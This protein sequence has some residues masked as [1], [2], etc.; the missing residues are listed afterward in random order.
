M[1]KDFTEGKRKSFSGFVS[2]IKRQDLVLAGKLLGNFE[3]SLRAI[4]KAE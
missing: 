1:F 2:S 4:A 3:R